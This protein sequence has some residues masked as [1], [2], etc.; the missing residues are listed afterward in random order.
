M[1][2]SRVCVQVP[3]SVIYHQLSRMSP[4][5]LWLALWLKYSWKLAS[6]CKWNLV[7][8][9]CC[10][11]CVLPNLLSGRRLSRS[12]CSGDPWDYQR[13]S[14]QFTCPLFVARRSPLIMDLR[15]LGL[16]TEISELIHR[17]I[18]RRSL[19][20]KQRFNQPIH[21]NFAVWATGLLVSKKNVSCVCGSHESLFCWNHHKTSCLS[22]FLSTQIFLFL[23]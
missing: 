2:S 3:V 13:P 19:M 15:R 16:L 22:P 11:R 23:A 9:K 8:W 14:Q 21:H 1:T 6:R 17:K 12:I 5:L 4:N 20:S 10:R 18:R 7:V